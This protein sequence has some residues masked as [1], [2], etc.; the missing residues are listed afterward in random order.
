MNNK[1]T[2]VRE[3]MLAFQQPVPDMPTTPDLATQQFRFNLVM[4]EA[5]ETQRDMGNRTNRMDGIC[6]MMYVIYGW[7]NTLGIEIET[8]HQQA[9]DP[10]KWFESVAHYCAFAARTNATLAR[11]ALGLALGAIEEM[12]AFNF[13]I[14]PDI[15]KCFAEVHRSNMSKLWSAEEIDRI[16]ADCTATLTYADG[17]IVKRSD[18]KV[19]KSPSYLP[20]NLEQFLK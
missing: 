2:K 14:A 19:I 4:E 5:F 12:A 8:V 20:A 13:E 18:G 16:P 9:K 17:Y 7:G 15:D 11:D 10:S 3:F 6:D 1:Q